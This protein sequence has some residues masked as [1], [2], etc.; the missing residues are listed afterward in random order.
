MIE[1]GEEQPCHVCPLSNNLHF[2]QFLG[3]SQKFSFKYPKIDPHLSLHI[4][5]FHMH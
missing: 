5:T 3:S 2:A 1:E 4:N